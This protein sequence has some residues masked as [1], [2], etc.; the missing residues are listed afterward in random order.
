MRDPKSEHM[1][2][3]Q[4]VDYVYIEDVKVASIDVEKSLHNQARI[5]PPLYKETVTQ[6]AEALDDGAE[7]PALIGYYTSDDKIVLID[8]NH[9]LG[10]HIKHGTKTV[11]VYI[12][13]AAADVVQALTYE[14]NATHGRPPTEEERVRHAI[15]LKDLGYT[16]KDAARV[17]SLSE[18]KV[19]TEW[20]HETMRRRARKLGLTKPFEAIPKS[21]WSKIN[22]IQNDDVFK[23]VVSFIA[24]SKSLTRIEITNLISQVREQTTESTQLKVL[25]EFKLAKQNE[26]RT[27]GRTR[28][29]Q[30]A[31]HGILPHLGYIIQADPEA[32]RNASLTP[33]QRT[34]V[35]RQLTKT[36]AVCHSIM[37]LLVEADEADAPAETD[38]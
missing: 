1:L 10:A 27:E 28:H 3:G 22:A 33:E 25:E 31:R 19:S 13:D 4:L 30:D 38:E 12:V 36:V 5:D 20:T 26:Q 15:H 11:D 8:G 21:Y 18:H 6:Y 32:I 24:A 37:Q 14:A 34:H 7:F 29:R 17:V 35:K 16:N 9:R 23:V 2:D